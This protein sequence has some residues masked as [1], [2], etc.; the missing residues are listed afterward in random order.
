VLRGLTCPHSATRHHGDL[1]LCDS[2]FGAI[3]V[4]DDV[5]RGVGHSSLSTVARLPGFTRGLAFAGGRAIV[6]LS[7]VIDRY[8]PYAPGLDPAA[9]RCGLAIVD[10]ATG[11]VEAQLWWPNGL[12]IYEVQTLPSVTRPTLPSSP[13]GGDD[14]HLRFLG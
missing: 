14:R 4:V 2:G 8:E 9:S 10:A 6:G 12:Q 5:C 3:G 13:A 7:K 1:W 11:V